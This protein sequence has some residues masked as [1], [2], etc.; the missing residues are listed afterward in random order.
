LEGTYD[1]EANTRAF[2]DAVN[3]FRDAGKE[4]KP[5]AK[6]RVRF[7][8]DEPPQEERKVSTPIAH[9]KSIWAA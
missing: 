2:Q 3:D 5:D 4:N 7:T 9:G 8:D 6:R 1:E